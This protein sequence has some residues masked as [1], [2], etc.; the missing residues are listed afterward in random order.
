MGKLVFIFALATGWACAADLAGVPNFHQVDDHLYR[1]AQP[2]AEG[3]KNLAKIGI[4]TVID[5]RESGEHEFNEQAIVTAAGM[6][7]I[8]LGMN[9]SHAPSPSQIADLL[10]TIDR[11]SGPIFIHCRRGAD[12][13][14]TVVACYRIARQNWPNAKALDEARQDGMSWTEFSMQTFIIHFR[15]ALAGIPAQAVPPAPAPAQR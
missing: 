11:E 5:L 13:T 6:H 4:K 3:F 14:G 7:Y 9:G 12:R 8:H 2:S 1:G 10:A 15:A